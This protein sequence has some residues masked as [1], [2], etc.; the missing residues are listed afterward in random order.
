LIELAELGVRSFVTAL[1]G[2]E[3]ERFAHDVIP[4]VRAAL[5]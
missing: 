1:G 5:P 3:H 2:A 4:A